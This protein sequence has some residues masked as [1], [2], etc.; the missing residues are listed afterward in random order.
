MD[1]VGPDSP[2]FKLLASAYARFASPQQMAEF[3]FMNYNDA[4]K[5]NVLKEMTLL[6]AMQHLDRAP[7]GDFAVGACRFHTHGFYDFCAQKKQGTL[8]EQRVADEMGDE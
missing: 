4:F 8:E 2:I 7:A 6:R 5:C 3:A 1:W